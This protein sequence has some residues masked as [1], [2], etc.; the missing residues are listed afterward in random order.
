VNVSCVD[1]LEDDTRDDC[2]AGQP[3][4]NRFCQCQN[5]DQCADGHTCIEGFCIRLCTA[6]QDC[7]S[8]A[9]VPFGGD[10]CAANCTQE[11]VR[12]TRLDPA[13]SPLRIQQASFTL[14]LNLRGTQVLRT[15]RPRTR[16]VLDP[17]GNVITEPGELPVTVKAADPA[18]EPLV[19][20]NLACACI[21]T[22][23][24]PDLFGPNIAGV[25]KI[26]CGDEGLH[27]VDYTIIQDHNTTP[28]NPGNGNVIGGLPQ[29]PDD[30]ECDDE[31]TFP[32]GVPSTA[33]R[34]LSDPDCSDPTA[35]FHP[36][37][38]N[39]PRTTRSSGAGP[40]GSA[41]ID[42]SI[43]IGL[44]S[45]AGSCDLTEPRNPDG[46]CRFRDYGPD[47]I[48]CTSD[49]RDM[50]TP[51]NL[52]LT[53]GVAAGAVY[54]AGNVPSIP[55]YIDAAEPGREC[56]SNDQCLLHEDCVRTCAQS[57]FLCSSDGDCGSLQHPNDACRSRRCEVLCEFGKRCLISQT[58]APFSC[59]LLL[60]EPSD[61]LGGAA[62]AFTFADVDARQIGDNVTSA[63]LALE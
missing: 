20:R 51:E 59:D 10:G 9:C 34:E 36:G 30:P 56:V 50:G 19:V 47:C 44:L 46:S 7:P 17:Q 12:R 45:D 24:V 33:C 52:T 27:A 63:L 16:R 61:G 55:I 8:G 53:T 6:S 49:D 37:V 42:A 29:L 58:G 22:V 25:G 62:L 26:A 54:D 28:G 60:A 3:C 5:D 23:P 35:F 39:S 38:C 18:F 43:A 31:F 57:G 21:R 15:G 11:D 2:P 13:R 1:Q 41:S 32:S 48:P 40:R 14:N 4:V